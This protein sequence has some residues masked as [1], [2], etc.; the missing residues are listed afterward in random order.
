M[1]KRKTSS[2]LFRSFFPS[3]LRWDAHQAMPRAAGLPLPN[4]IND[5]SDCLPTPQSE[6][7]AKI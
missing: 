5:S 3:G 7:G 2:Q 4:L 6:L 1:M